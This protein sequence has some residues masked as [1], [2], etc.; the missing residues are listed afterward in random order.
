MKNISLAFFLFNVF[1]IANFF[2]ELE[3]RAAIYAPKKPSQIFLPIEY[4]QEDLQKSL[5]HLFRVVQK[6]IV[7]IDDSFTNNN[8]DNLKVRS[9]QT[10]DIDL[11]I[12][13][14]IVKTTVPIHTYAV[15]SFKKTVSVNLL[16]FKKDFNVNFE[17]E[18]DF[19]MVVT[20]TTS[21]EQDEN[22]K[23]N[24]STEWEFD[25]KTVPFISFLFFSVSVLNQVKPII[26]GVLE[27]YAKNKIDKEVAKAVDLK[28]IINDINKTLV[29]PI[30]LSE[31]YGLY[32]YFE[33]FKVK[34]D[35]LILED[36]KI[37]FNLFLEAYPYLSFSERTLLPLI[38][39][40][41]K[42]I[43]EKLSPD[44]KLGKNDF[45]LRPVLILTPLDFQNIIF[46]QISRKSYSFG[47]NNFAMKLNE[48][49]S[50]KSAN[51]FQFDVFLR[52]ETEQSLIQKL[53]V[54]INTS[55]YFNELNK[56]IELVNFSYSVDAKNV[57]LQV[58]NYFNQKNFES[59]LKK[60]IEEE[61]DET[62]E[63]IKELI[64]TNIKEVNIT[65]KSLLHLNVGSLTVD[66]LE[67][68]DEAVVVYL[69]GEGNSYLSLRNLF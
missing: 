62:V 58:A 46:N 8:N 5:N 19:A 39:K 42:Q 1:I 29:D 33:I 31:R 60:L 26:E 51:T 63:E 16:F 38:I 27:D 43:F 52:G 24:P 25:F 40:D 17:R 68:I 14:G 35:G 44:E 4:P 37:T 22:L 69:E 3:L 55:F 9:V 48:I 32:G 67:I 30:L 20:F 12:A 47:Q 6:D 21:V 18:L 7:F 41:K 64:K 66:D 2:A 13:D 23:L 15:F 56:K 49:Y 59:R 54:I 65:D 57:I 11:Q 61:L 36:G 10:D 45:F 34:G 28:K 50:S 53:L